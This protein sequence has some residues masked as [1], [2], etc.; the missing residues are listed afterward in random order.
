MSQEELVRK[1]TNL[2]IS[3]EAAGSSSNVGDIL[4]NFLK[5]FTVTLQEIV[6]NKKSDLR[7]EDVEKSFKKFH[8]DCRLSILSWLKHFEE[9]SEVFEL[10]PLQKLI[11]AKRLSQGNAKLFVE[12]ESTAVN[13]DE[14]ADELFAEYGKRTESALIH[15][16]LQERR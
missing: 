16:R 2:N 4:T 13:F 7:F 1:F 6:P 14:L 12:L 11:Y 5:Q 9:Q 10:K 8:G 15:Q 3:N